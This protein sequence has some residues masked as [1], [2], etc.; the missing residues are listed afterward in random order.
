MFSPEEMQQLFEEQ[1][2]LEMNTYVK[3]KSIDAEKHKEI[4][5]YTQF[6]VSIIHNLPNL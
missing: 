1:F 2:S 4:S 3:V 6:C 5:S